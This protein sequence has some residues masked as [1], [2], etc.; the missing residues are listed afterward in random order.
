MRKM[1]ITLGSL[2]LGVSKNLLHL[3]QATTGIVQVLPELQA[4]YQK[5]VVERA[6]HSA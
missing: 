5:L 1:R 2:D 3:I 4:L 6:K